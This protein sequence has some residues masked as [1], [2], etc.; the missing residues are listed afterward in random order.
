MEYEQFYDYDS[1][2]GAGEGYDT[3]SD[4]DSDND[5]EDTAIKED[6]DCVTSVRCYRCRPNWTVA[7]QIQ[8]IVNSAGGHYSLPE[9][10]SNMWKH[11]NFART[12]NSMLPNEGY[13]AELEW[14]SELWAMDVWPCPNTRCRSKKCSC[15]PCSDRTLNDIS[16]Y[17]LE[18]GA[19]E[20][21]IIGN[22]NEE[23]AREL[24]INRW[25]PIIYSSPVI[26]DVMSHRFI[27]CDSDQESEDECDVYG[28]DSDSSDSDSHDIRHFEN[29]IAMMGY[30]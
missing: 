2:S 6:C 5:Y 14:P 8:R 24:F 7:H 1:G 16:L 22:S 29:I 13:E 27:M 17:R 10:E 19:L 23:K 3:D 21:N 30:R 4:S 15:G 25:R 20:Q 9:V 12:V 11:R 18:R 26:E 28:L